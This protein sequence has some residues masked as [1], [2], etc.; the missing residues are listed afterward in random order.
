MPPPLVV[1]ILLPL[2]E[3]TARSPCAAGRL[4]AVGRAERLGGV[5]DERDA[6]LGAERA[7]RVVVAA[8][9]VEVDGDDRAGSRGRS[10]S[11]RSSRSGSIVQVSASASTNTGVAPT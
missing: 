4:A 9:A 1:I 5:L 3:K 11:A 8:L 6:V 7:D 2:N 10:A